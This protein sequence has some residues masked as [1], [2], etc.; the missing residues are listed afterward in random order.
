MERAIIQQIYDQGPDAVAAVIAH[1]ETEISD[2]RARVK[3]LEDRLAK[4]S[5]NSHLPPSR[6]LPPKPKS[7]RKPSGRTPGGQPGHAG[8][9]LSWS[10][11]P[12]H[13]VVHH[14]AIC[15]GCGAMLD[16]AT[17]VGQAR[18]QVVDLPPL[19]LMTTEYV[20]E[21]RRCPCCG[22]LT[23]A[24]FPAAARGSVSYGPRLRGLA[25][26]LQTYQLLPYARL[27]ELVRDLFGGS[28]SA[29]TLSTA[30][31]DCD[32]AL[33]ETETAIQQALQQEAVAH[34]DETGLRVDG[35]QQWLHVAGTDRL[36]HY[37]VDPKRGRAGMAAAGVLPGFTGVAVHDGL[38]GYGT[39]PCEHALCNVHHLRDLTFVAE[40]YQQSWADEFKDLLQELQATVAT[41]RDAGQTHL[42]P[43]TLKDATQRFRNLAKA[44]ERANPAKPKAPSTPGPPKRTKAGKLAE[45]L[46]RHELEALLFLHDF[47]VPFDNNQ[48]E[49]DLR[50]LKVQQK[51][52]GTF[53]TAR[54]AAQFA[55]IRGYV[56]T[57]RK[58]GHN[59][60]TALQAAC[61]GHPLVLT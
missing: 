34:F 30:I 46:G 57:A 39:F 47:R 40:Q 43:T 54:G 42:A 15:A 18:R 8:T 1:L 9:T 6:D 31:T 24:I 22:Q 10:A 56:S 60:L 19:R 55:R 36:T 44:G 29:G 32:G 59:P 5:H 11:E 21:Q 20:V 45:W 4:D 7:L 52:S 38:H 61:A 28:F 25:V 58:Q 26:Y 17:V 27:E 2:L 35:A 37:R 53:R 48:A 14:P 41:A 50:M 51:I 33:A 23:P 13:T 16:A 49:R 12:D 3:A